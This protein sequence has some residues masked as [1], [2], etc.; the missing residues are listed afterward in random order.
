VPNWSISRNYKEIRNSTKISVTPGMHLTWGGHVQ[1]PLMCGPSGWPAGQTPWSAGPLCSLPWV[2]LAVMIYKRRWNGTEGLESV[3]AMLDG[4]LASWLG[5]LVNTWQIIDL[6]KS[7]TTPRTPINTPL[8]MEFNTPHYTSNSPLVSFWF[9]SRSAGEPHQES[10]LRSSSE[11]S[12]RDRWA[13]VSLPFFID[14]E[15]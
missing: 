6:I 3:E 12:L 14:F 4:W 5:R 7:A 2:S 11:S 8:L 15:L 1:R 13:I 10:S 9:S